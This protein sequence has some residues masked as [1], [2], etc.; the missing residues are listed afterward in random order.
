MPSYIDSVLALCFVYYFWYVN[1]LCATP[2]FYNSGSLDVVFDDLNMEIIFI[3]QKKKA[4]FDNLKQII[5]AYTNWW[6]F[7]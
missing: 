4:Q 2:F 3:F 1:V 7:Y 6:V 5:N